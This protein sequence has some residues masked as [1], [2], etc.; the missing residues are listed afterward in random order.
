M[1]IPTIYAPQFFTGNNSTS[2]AYVCSWKALDIANLRVIETDSL[3]VE[4]AVLSHGSGM[5]VTLVGNTVEFITDTAIPATSSVVGFLTSDYLQSRNLQNSSNNDVNVREDMFDKLT[6]MLQINLAGVSETAGLPIT[7]PT[8]ENAPTQTLPT[9]PNRGDS[10]LYFDSNGD[11]TVYSY[12]TLLLNLQAFLTTGDAGDAL[13]NQIVNFAASKTIAQTDAFKLWLGDTSSGDLTVTCPQDSAVTI[14]IGS[15][16][17]FAK[18]SASN[19]ILFV[20]GA[21]AT[22]QSA[23]GATP[24]IDAQHAGATLVKVSANTWKLFGRISAA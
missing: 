9:A 12:A 3:G 14:S 20:A 13:A 17:D 2:T 7:F 24:Q 23:S 19:N 5:T 22:L 8:S 4:G 16:L 1:S 10:F 6:L 11:L 18:E 21:G 15:K